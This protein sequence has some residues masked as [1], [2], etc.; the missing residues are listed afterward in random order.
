MCYETIRQLNI[1]IDHAAVFSEQSLQNDEYVRFYTSY[2]VLKTLYDFVVPPIEYFN[3]NPTKL[4]SFQE[5]MVVLAKLRLDSPLKNFVYKFNV[6]VATVSRVLL[7]WLT[8]LDTKLRPL[9]KW[10]ERDVL[11]ISTLSCYPASFGKKVVVIL[12]CFEIF[13]E[14]PSNLLLSKS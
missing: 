12:D 5:F 1:N 7:K 4:T 13:I 9:I 3:K 2:T 10:P 6:S 8:V 11:F 14:R